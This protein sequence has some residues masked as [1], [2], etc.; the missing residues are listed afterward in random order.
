MRVKVKWQ[1]TLWILFAGLI[2]SQSVCAQQLFTTAR[3]GGFGSP[4]LLFGVS[5]TAI[6]EDR[7]ENYT[8]L[9]ARVSVGIG[10]KTDIFGSFDGVLADDVLN[11]KF[12][13]W[14]A[15][16]KHQFIRTGIVDIGALVRFRGNITDRIRFED[17]LFDFAGMISFEASLVHP[18]YALVFS[19]PFGFDFN[20][21]F[22]R[23]SVFGVEVPLGDVPRVIGEFSLGDRRSFGV[24]FKLDF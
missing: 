6:D 23:T 14:S 10:R 20:D 13:A 8:L 9:T 7:G 5:Y 24:A 4:S 19:R 1:R 2:L 12:G 11:T 22:Q 16:I 15:G 17:A 18:Y 21:D 3:T